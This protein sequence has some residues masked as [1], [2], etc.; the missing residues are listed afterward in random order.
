MT[1]HKKLSREEEAYRDVGHTDISK[2]GSI[3]L[4][5]FF[6]LLIISIPI[7]QLM[8][9]LFLE[10]KTGGETLPRILAVAEITPEPETP[11]ELLSFLPPKS[12][13][14]TFETRIENNSFLLKNLLPW[15]QT[16][17]CQVGLGNAKTFIG[18][19]G[20]LFFAKDVQ[21][22][23][24]I[25]FLDPEFLTLRIKA[26]PAD[27]KDFQPDPLPAILDFRDELRERGIELVLLPVPVK[28]SV[29]PE[30]L[31]ASFQS[32]SG[33]IH[34]PGYA[35]WKGRL[36]E[37]GVRVFPV[38]EILEQAK[39]SSGKPLYL[40][41]DT[42][43]SP[44]AMDR[45]S[46]ELAEYLV[47]NRLAAKRE[48]RF[49]KRMLEVS[50]H[51][52]I[53][54]MLKLPEKQSIYKEENITAAVYNFGDT[55][56]GVKSTEVLLLGDSF[57]NIYS[58]PEMHW[59]EDGGLTEALSYHLGQRVD[60][61]VRNDN[62][63][64]ATRLQLSNDLKRG[65]DRLAGKKVVVW[66]FVCRELSQGDWKVLNYKLDRNAARK[67]L[68]TS[69]LITIKGT[70]KEITRPP[71]PGTS[72]YQNSII[73][74]HLTDVQIEGDQEKSE[75]IVVFAFG[76]KENELTEASHWK[77]GDRLEKHVIAWERV[78]H[79]FGRLQRV[80][81][82][83]PDTIL[84]D[85]FWIVSEDHAELNDKPLEKSPVE[86]PE[87]IHLTT[88]ERKSE[89]A[90]SATEMQIQDAFA[91]LKL[92]SAG[93]ERTEA[94][95]YQGED[96]WLFFSQE[97]VH[98]LKGKFWG[99]EAVTTGVASNEKAR[100]PLPAILDFKAQ[101]D[102]KNIKLIMAVVPAKAA[103]YPD[104]IAPD[105]AGDRLASSKHLLQN[106]KKFLDILK[107][108]GIDVLPL[109]TMFLDM[110]ASGEKPY[111]REDT[112]W[113]PVAIDVVAKELAKRINAMEFSGDIS[114]QKFRREIEKIRITGDL[115]T[116][117]DQQQGTEEVEVARVVDAATER[118]S[119]V[120]LIGDSHTLVFSDG[121]KLHSEDA[122][123][124]EQ[125]MYHLGFKIDM[126]GI[127]GSG[128]TPARA[129]LARR[130]DSLKGKRVVI[131]CFTARE[132]TEANSGWHK[133][134]VIR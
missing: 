134:P 70:I 119:P 86:K 59:G 6:L 84:M 94:M 44:G 1:E 85:L 22:A 19:D 58:D 55:V 63:S 34:N 8:L 33:V 27:S 61:I 52:D 88:K 30:K 99:T 98:L 32:G 20:W 124:A 131:W 109:D 28:P 47:K 130:R 16:L 11:G 13:I 95:A 53:T 51:G 100:D 105:L 36:Q 42:H 81:L 5:S 75:D 72:A 129:A 123:L 49:R 68:E 76:L 125:L 106:Y 45:V 80:E 122:G 101:L 54:R 107:D 23:M 79:K 90:S 25:N 57:T 50:S 103:L 92:I 31:S 115:R 7:I 24:G 41:R 73:A 38:D 91:L 39:R 78:E 48:A 97:F 12:K 9:E 132:F 26:A 116:F 29:Y 82:E 117:L 3:V 46:A 14:K 56:A 121:G 120:I 110:R 15:M 4:T 96:G 126:V 93:L 67:S 104:K 89:S 40:E 64:Y 60:A 74:V 128:A 2:A 127:R 62:G 18:R 114:K 10:D 21:H 118:S 77:K 133:V 108:N 66:Q 43:W 87:D 102:K 65:K 35:L 37:A 113:S 111:L 112:H 17:F 69:G 71:Q 83:N